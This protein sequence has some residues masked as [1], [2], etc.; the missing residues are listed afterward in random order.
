MGK[1]NKELL[2]EKKAGDNLIAD[3]TADLDELKQQIASALPTL[4]A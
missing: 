2:K 1:R 3:L 4:L